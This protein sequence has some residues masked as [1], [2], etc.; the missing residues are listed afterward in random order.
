MKEGERKG[1]RGNR[2]HTG[3]LFLS[4]SFLRNSLPQEFSWV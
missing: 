3:M 2:K 1:W 4:N